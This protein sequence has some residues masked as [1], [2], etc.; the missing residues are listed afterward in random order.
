MMSKYQKEDQIEYF[1]NIMIWLLK[2]LCKSAVLQIHEE[3]K[4]DLFANFTTNFHFPN[5]KRTWLIIKRGENF[6]KY[7]QQFSHAFDGNMREC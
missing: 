1:T 4:H 5:K 6:E 7:N 3:N 2:I